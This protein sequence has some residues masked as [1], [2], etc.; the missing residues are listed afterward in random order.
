MAGGL[1]AGWRNAGQAGGARRGDERL[2]HDRRGRAGG[3]DEDRRTSSSCRARARPSQPGPGAGDG[4]RQRPRLAVDGLAVP[5]E[6]ENATTCTE[7]GGPPL[8]SP[9][10]MVAEV[11][12][13]G[14]LG[15]GNVGGAAGRALTTQADE[16]AG[17]T[18][19]RLEVARVA[20]R[21]LS[22]ERSVELPDG[23]LTTDAA[24]VVAD[25]G[26]D[27]VVEVIGGI[28][29]AR[30]ADPRRPRPTA[31][32]S[33][34][35]TRSCSPTSAPSCSPPPTPPAR[36]CCSRR[37]SP[38]ASRSSGRCAESLVGER[39]QPGARHRQRHDELHPHPHDR[40]R[41]PSTARPSPRPSA[42]GTPSATRPP[43]SRAS[44]PAPRRRSSPRSPSAPGSWPATCTTRASAASR[45]PTSPTP[46]KLGYVVKLLAIAE[47]RRRRLRSAC[48][49]TRRMVPTTHPLASVR[50]SY[51]AVFVEGEAVGNLMFYGR[52]AGGVPTASAVLGDLI[53]AAANLRKGAHA[54]L[55]SLAKAADPPDRRRLQRVLPQRRGGRPARRARRGRR[56]L[57]RPRRVDPGDGAGGPRRRG[58]ARVHHPH[59]RRARRAGDAARPPRARRGASASCRVLRV[60][61][62]RS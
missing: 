52:G 30:D 28:E 33:S 37:R 48:A 21:S 29:P 46:R 41:A 13:V 43:T 56:R 22:K 5:S 53:D 27:V 44:T 49:S 54:S 8:P 62:V 4:R 23:V 26:I 51:N 17:R 57:R 10:V 55:G 12:R 16:I 60:V 18:G 59:R 42:S 1:D 35:A 20:V 32:R 14:L 47:P 50:D 25:P 31:S 38:A 15:C 19:V 45:R 36:T 61:I 9:T 6:P 40:G 3:D 7:S 11:V 24:D 2:V 39:I 34:P 58:P